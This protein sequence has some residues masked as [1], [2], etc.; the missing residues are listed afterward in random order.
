MYFD[1]NNSNKP[2]CDGKALTVKTF[3][4][5]FTCG[6]CSCICDENNDKSD[7]YISLDPVTSNKDDN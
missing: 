2:Y 6:A 7:R 5:G 1:S 3:P 4:K